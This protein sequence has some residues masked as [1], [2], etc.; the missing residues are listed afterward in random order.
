MREMGGKRWSEEELNDL[1]QM[2]ENNIPLK[3]MAKELGRTE[4]VVQN[5]LNFSLG[6]L[7]KN[8]KKNFNHIYEVGEEV[9]GMKIIKQIRSSDRR[10]SIKSYIVE[11]LAF[12]EA[13]HYEISESNIRQSKRCAYSRGIRIFEGNSLYS[14]ERI[15][16][17]IIDIEYA[18]KIAPNHSDIESIIYLVKHT[19]YRRSY[20]EL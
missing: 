8:S 14:I 15:R 20:N 5:K 18:K 3:T 11:S 12:P 10:S 2:N 13:P 6:I 4:Y 17:N 19:F 16:N 7:L 9:N 1:K